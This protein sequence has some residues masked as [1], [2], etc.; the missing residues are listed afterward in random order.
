MRSLVAQRGSRTNSRVGHKSSSRVPDVTGT[1][2]SAVGVMN[3]RLLASGGRVGAVDDRTALADTVEAGTD[4]VVLDARTLDI[5]I[6]GGAG[7]GVGSVLIVRVLVAGR[8]GGS[9]EGD[10][11]LDGDLATLLLRHLARDGDRC[12]V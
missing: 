2:R 8:G 6:A 11:V 1:K 10:L 3:E 12:D 4:G 7:T 5:G 9:G